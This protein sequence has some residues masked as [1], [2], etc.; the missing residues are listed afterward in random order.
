METSTLLTAPAGT[1]KSYLVTKEAVELLREESVTIITNM[2]WGEV[3]ETHS[4]PPAFDGETFVD[5]ISE[6][7]GRDVSHQIR[8]IPAD[9]LKDWRDYKGGGP[10]IWLDDEDLSGCRV[11][12]DEAHNYAPRTGAQ[13][14][15]REWQQFCGELRHRGASVLFVTQHP[16]KL[17]RE[18]INE[19]GIRFA[20]VNCEAERDPFFGIELRYWYELRAKLTGSYVAAFAKI[21]LRD[22]DGSKSK[23]S[24]VERF[25]RDPEIFKLY[26]SFSAPQA[27]GHG[28]TLEHVRE[29]SRRGWVSLLWWFG[30]RNASRFVR[31]AFVSVA[32]VLL[33]TKGHLVFG[34]LVD[35]FTSTV[36]PAQKDR[37]RPAIEQT[38]SGGEKR[39]RERFDFVEVVSPDPVLRMV[40]TNFAIFD[41]GLRYTVGDKIKD[42]DSDAKVVKI[43]YRERLVRLDSGRRYALGGVPDKPE[44]EDNSAAATVRNSAARRGRDRGSEAGR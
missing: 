40:T 21:E 38:V 36:T 42:G 4:T 19:C 30:S 23:R 37:S 5:R 15:A 6:Y 35:S 16:A 8:L 7:I 28:A 13:H 31:P 20:L 25:A 22:I 33:I 27:G 9:V 44:A 1:G 14:K 29:F 41:D 11:I 2:P 24:N 32:V 10:W 26:D 43:D 12:L 34:L 3:P 39:D 17:A 18:I